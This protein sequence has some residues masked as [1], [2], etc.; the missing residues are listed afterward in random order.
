MATAIATQAATAIAA[1]THT[2]GH[3][4]WLSLAAIILGPL[5]GI[6]VTRLIDAAGETRKQRWDVFVTLMRTK[7]LELTPDHVAA[8]NMI[9]VLF[10]KHTPV[11]SA[12]GELMDVL[13]DVQLNS[14][15][16]SV[17]LDVNSNIK[18]KRSNLLAQVAS[19]VDAKLPDK[20]EHRVGYAPLAWLNEQQHTAEARDQLL[21]VLR[22]EQHIQMVAGIYQLPPTPEA[23]SVPENKQPEA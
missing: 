12:W 15:D 18:S 8:I 5:V 16:E 14:D 2:P 10:A 13:N 7:G 9:P 21:R 20:D 17:R 6:W 22:G 19:A 23:L 3:F 4:E 1:H 11:I